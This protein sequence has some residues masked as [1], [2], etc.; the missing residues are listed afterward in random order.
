MMI[1]HVDEITPPRDRATGPRIN[2]ILGILHGTYSRLA[3]NDAILYHAARATCKIDHSAK[4]AP[5]VSC[6]LHDAFPDNAIIVRDDVLTAR[7]S[8]ALDK[9]IL[10]NLTVVSASNNV[11]EGCK[12]D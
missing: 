8:I 2:P 6:I 3:I 7:S 9:Q 12:R 1:F 5:N 11:I 4:A 10:K